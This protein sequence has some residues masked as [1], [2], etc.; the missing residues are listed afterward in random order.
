M[1]QYFLH[2]TTLEMYGK[3]ADNFHEIYKKLNFLFSGNVSIVKEIWYLRSISW[4]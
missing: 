4:K 3:T 2:I 1:I